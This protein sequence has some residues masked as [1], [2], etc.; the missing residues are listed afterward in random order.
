MDREETE[1]TTRNAIE[2]GR[3]RSTPWLA[4][5]CS[6]GTLIGWLADAFPPSSCRPH[7]QQV[8]TCNEAIDV[9]SSTF[10]RWVDVITGVG[11]E[12][13]SLVVTSSNFNGESFTRSEFQSRN[14]TTQFV[15]SI[16]MVGCSSRCIYRLGAHE[17]N[18]AK[19]PLRKAFKVTLSVEGIYY[20]SLCRQCGA[21]KLPLHTLGW[22]RTAPFLRGWRS[23]LIAW[24]HQRTIACVI[25]MVSLHSHVSGDK[26]LYHLGRSPFHRS[27]VKSSDFT[28]KSGERN[29]TER[30]HVGRCGRAAVLSQ[31]R[32]GLH[33]S[34]LRRM[35]RLIVRD[36]AS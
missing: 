30:T 7:Q 24:C 21:I 26:R 31:R 12:T 1:Q 3:A 9:E 18:V 22:R 2:P 36:P 27:A 4:G 14:E 23:V 5:A 11:S 25:R 29:E 15:V 28:G 16:L 34:E 19:C 33:G 20:R 6:I 32:A 8:P 13:T 17:L 10:H 35:S